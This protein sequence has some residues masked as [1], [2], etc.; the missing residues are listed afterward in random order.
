MNNV[1]R[2]LFTLLLSFS[3]LVGQNLALAE[4]DI[5]DLGPQINSGAEGF[6]KENQTYS[7]RKKV[8]LSNSEII[9]QVTMFA[10]AGMGTDMVPGIGDQCNN[11]TPD[12]YAYMGGSA[13][14]MIAQ[15]ISQIKLAKA[16]ENHIQ[17][18]IQ[19]SGDKASDVE[20]LETMKKIEEERLKATKAKKTAL[21]IL[22]G[23]YILSEVLALTWMFKDSIQI[24]NT[25]CSG[26]QAVAGCH[27]AKIVMN[28]PKVPLLAYG[29][30][31]PNCNATTETKFDLK[32]DGI[33]LLNVGMACSSQQEA[34]KPN[35]MGLAMS[36]GIPALTGQPL[37]SIALSVLLDLGGARC[38]AAV[39]NAGKKFY[40]RPA[41]KLLR[42][43]ILRA[44]YY[45][46]AMAI[47]GINSST[48]KKKKNEIEENIADLSQI[49][50]DYKSKH[51]SE[52]G[53]G[54][55]SLEN[56]DWEGYYADYQAGAFPPGQGP[57]GSEHLRQ[58][59][60]ME[61]GKVSLGTE[62][63]SP[64][65]AN[66]VAALNSS[67][68]A[69][70]DG[71]YGKALASAEG[72][73]RNIAKLKKIRDG[74]RVKVNDNLKKAGLKPIDFDA[75]ANSIA[76]DLN[77]ASG[78]AT[79]QAPQLANAL[80]EKPKETKQEPKAV[81]GT[82]EAAKVTTNSDLQADMEQDIFAEDFEKEEMF[83]I[84]SSSQEQ[85]LN[86]FVVNDKDIN[87]N[88]S[89]SIFKLLSVRYLKTAYPKLLEEAK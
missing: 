75:R 3:F 34:S 86:D 46:A 77:S 38:M 73:G 57:Y 79:N 27:A 76:N 49:I 85:D 25:L 16:N 48:T 44:G 45:A 47:T 60:Q 61:F 14:Y 17:E 1:F 65:V 5:P 2:S 9:D 39:M 32:K 23:S 12:M 89:G 80:S 50:T 8:D 58:I 78:N 19:L 31:I 69:I 51:T 63:K 33:S 64:T 28:L 55:G 83:D 53:V 29:Q 52:G 26:P 15:V 82:Q 36:A 62:L 71:Q 11:Y 18:Q 72:L 84:A 4:G 42:K 30:S 68:K 22:M 66:S 43:H 56:I 10:A 81:A 21:D 70:K 6:D 87:K 40:K 13:I 74:L 37:S 24:A 7:L 88:R 41:Y 35:V 54:E 59:S 67:T 20:S